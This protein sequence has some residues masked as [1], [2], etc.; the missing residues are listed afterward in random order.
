MATYDAPS[1]QSLSHSPYMF[2]GLPTWTR[3]L[4]TLSIF[5]YYIYIHPIFLI[6]NIKL[7]KKINLKSLLEESTPYHSFVNKD[8][9]R[10]KAQVKS[11]PNLLKLF[12]PTLP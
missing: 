12:E 9:I 11:I 5:I 6:F 4:P 7:Y 3:M 8:K 1:T 2:M 10:F